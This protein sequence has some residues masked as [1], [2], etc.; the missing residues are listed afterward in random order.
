MASSAVASFAVA[1]PA[2]ARRGRWR[3]LE[4]VRRLAILLH[5]ARGAGTEFVIENPVDRGDRDRKEFFI[6]EE[7]GPL[8][9]A[10]PRAVPS[11]TSFD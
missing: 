3:A 8:S 2:A 11:S 10:H 7:H 5:V 9:R 1:S 6:T 4:I